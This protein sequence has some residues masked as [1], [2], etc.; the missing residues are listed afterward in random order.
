MRRPGLRIAA[1]R[2]HA[3]TMTLTSTMKQ[4]KVIVDESELA[5]LQ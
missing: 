5:T 3:S 1:V 4:A 2:S